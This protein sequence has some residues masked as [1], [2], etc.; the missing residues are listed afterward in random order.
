MKVWKRASLYL[1]RNRKKTII[2][3]AILTV[4]ITLVMVCISVGNGAAAAMQNLREAMGGYFK[5]DIDREQGY[6]G[7]MEDGIVE[8]IMNFGGIKAYNG[9]DIRYMLAEELE[10]EPGR[11][12]SEGDKKAKL[13][14][15]LGNTDTSLNEY[16]VL[17]YFKLTQG[18]HITPE[19]H[20]KALISQELAERNGLSV[21]DRFSMILDTEDFTS[22]E[23]I[24]V[25]AH[26]LEVAGIYQIENRQG[27]SSFGGDPA[28]C[29]MEE[30]FIFTDTAYIREVYE[31]LI[32][33]EI[34]SYTNEV[35]FFV[36][37]PKEL[38]EIVEGI[39]QLPDYP[40]DEYVITK[41]NKTYEDSAGPLERLSGLV[42]VM[43]LVIV[44]ISAV[45][46]SLILFLW[47]RER[48]HEIGIY[49]SVGIRKA[50]LLGQH[51]LENLSVAVLA[52]FL[53]WAI[54]TAASGVT[55]QM[56]DKQFARETEE[57]EQVAGTH[58]ETEQ[59]E[60]SLVEVSIGLT[61]LAQI[62]GIGV[63]IIL[64]STGISA[65]LVLRMQPR[66]IFSKMS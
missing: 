17:E 41:N 4:I 64:F 21:G 55:G 49:L 10:L 22:E 53:A 3:L 43:V 66:D 35:A 30:N 15:V 32:G 20:G 38:D 54:A 47:M 27:S 37:N 52:F 39:T 56:V 2:L 45:M 60:E 28:E 7:N 31:E 23:E 6:T 34:H 40:W 18:R 58:Q 44:V 13:A 42:T 19:D 14:R 24:Q 11:F 57:T 16:F 9:Q 29:D 33:R 63:L 48:V 50:E 65:I 62:T 61:E 5:I 51:I 59:S 8:D 36:E 26:P 1:T 25:T 12:T 46:L